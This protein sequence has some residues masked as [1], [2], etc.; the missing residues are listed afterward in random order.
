[1]DFSLCALYEEIVQPIT[2]HV[3]GD[4]PRWLRGTLLRNGPGSL[5]VGS[6][7]FEHLFDSSALLHRFA[8]ADGEVTYNCRFL[9]SNTFKKNRAANRIVVTEMAAL[10][11]PG[12]SMSDNAMISITSHWRLW[13][14]KIST[15]A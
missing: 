9:S 15:K 11:N 1:M 7:R 14:G 3:T 4:I 2:G 5:N 8:I 10:F 13:R 12:E 6:M